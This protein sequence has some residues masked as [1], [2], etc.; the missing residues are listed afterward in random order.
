MNERK[1]KRSLMLQ[2]DVKLFP[3][4]SNQG[5]HWPSFL[6]LVSE[7]VLLQKPEYNL[8]FQGSIQNLQKRALFMKFY[9]EMP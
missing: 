7:L 4:C 1:S 8:E 3:Q 2:K 9:P 5:T 6:K